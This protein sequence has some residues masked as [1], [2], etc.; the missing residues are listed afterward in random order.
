MVNGGM[1]VEQ[2]KRV[3]ELI[4]RLRQRGLSNGASIGQHSGLYDEAADELEHLQAE[5]EEF[6]TAKAE[7]RAVIFPVALNEKVWLI[8]EGTLIMCTIRTLRSRALGGWT[9]RLYPLMQDWCAPRVKYYEVNLAGFNK[10][11]FKDYDKAVEA[12]KACREKQR[13]NR[14]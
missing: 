2:K 14:S 5:L 9:L 12:Q 7:W 13:G 4:A 8:R 6:Q 10:T 3:V 11:W 1:I